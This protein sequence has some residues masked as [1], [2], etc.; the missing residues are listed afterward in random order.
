MF[1]VSDGRI[2]GWSPYILCRPWV[3]MDI[4][5]PWASQAEE[6]HHGLRY[7]AH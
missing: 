2:G 6:G 1:V 5:K 4:E 3:R 7:S